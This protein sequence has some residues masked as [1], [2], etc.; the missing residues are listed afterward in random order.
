MIDD[1]DISEELQDS[2]NLYEEIGDGELKPGKQI[3]YIDRYTMSK[4][5]KN[6]SKYFGRP[7]LII[8]IIGCDNNVANRGDEASCY[9]PIVTKQWV[10]EEPEMK[11]QGRFLKAFFTGLGISDFK[12]SNIKTYLDQM[13]KMPFM[14]NITKV[15]N[16]FVQMETL[17]FIDSMASPIDI[18][19]APF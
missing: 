6:G 17:G 3:V 14:V 12:V 10:E 19:E 8:N 4:N 1:Y 7:Q 5:N 2:D 18:D 16:G 11:R 9:F 15:D 13:R